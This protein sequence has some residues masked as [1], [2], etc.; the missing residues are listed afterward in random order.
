MQ[1]GDPLWLIVMEDVLTRP[2]AEQIDWFLN[3][4]K[5]N[6]VPDAVIEVR[7]DMLGYVRPEPK[8][9]RGRPPKEK[10]E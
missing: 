3:H 10:Q 9:G 4:A 8:R 2:E 6:G 5:F 7:L 1:R